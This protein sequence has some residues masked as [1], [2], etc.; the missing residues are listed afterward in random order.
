MS[1][2]L[3]ENE[4]FMT[5]FKFV[6]STYAMIKQLKEKG[7]SNLTKEEQDFIDSFD[8]Y[9]KFAFNSSKKR[10]EE[11]EKETSKN[12]INVRCSQIKR[13]NIIFQKALK[14]ISELKASNAQLTDAQN[15]A[16]LAA[17]ESENLKNINQ[18]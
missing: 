12:Q 8:N 2:N 17:K 7:I 4:D 11:A 9:L 3:N 18:K 16:L 15:I 6:N 1:N 14:E 5:T 10:E 13:E